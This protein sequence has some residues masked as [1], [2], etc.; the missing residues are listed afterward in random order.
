MTEIVT[1]HALIR[2]LERVQGLDMEW[3]RNHVHEIVEPYVK[4]RVANVEIGGFWFIFRNGKLVTISP[5]RPGVSSEFRN[6]RE[7]VNGTD[8]P[9]ETLNWKARKRRRAHR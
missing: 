1:D 5:D 8:Q 3:F 6:Q 9:R 7:I 2:Y 4:A